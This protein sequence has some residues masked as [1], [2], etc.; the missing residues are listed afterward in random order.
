MPEWCINTRCLDCESHAIV[1]GKIDCNYMNRLGL[2]QPTVKSFMETERT[3]E[4]VDKE[5]EDLEKTMA[6][7]ETRRKLLEELK[8]KTGGVG[9]Q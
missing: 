9:E 7:I 6:E 5:L 2:S 1:K 4:Q 8:G 3:P